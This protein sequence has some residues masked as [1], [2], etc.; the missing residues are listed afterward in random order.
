MSVTTSI[1]NKC[2]PVLIDGAGY[3][4]SAAWRECKLGAW[5]TPPPPHHSHQ[6]LPDP[7]LF[8]SFPPF[9]YHHSRALGLLTVCL[10]EETEPLTCVT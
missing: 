7:P 8:L 1:I 2:L 6:H 10:L 4:L 3:I 9:Y 5:R